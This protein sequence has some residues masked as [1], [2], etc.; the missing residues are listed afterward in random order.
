M[1]NFNLLLLLLAGALFCS[2]TNSSQKKTEEEN[3]TMIKVAYQFLDVLK[4]NDTSKVKSMLP[5]GLLDETNE[6]FA[7]NVN[8]ASGAINKYGIPKKNTVSFDNSIHNEPP[9]TG[10]LI[11]IYKASNP[12]D[13]F[14]KAV[15]KIFVTKTSNNYQVLYFNNE[16]EDKKEQLKP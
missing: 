16:F 6:I 13:E 11:P 2:C 1:R 5:Y 4:T 7:Y 15:I 12:E 10:I 14:Q 8:L 9:V 3:E